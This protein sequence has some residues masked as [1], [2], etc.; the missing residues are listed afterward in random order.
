MWDEEKPPLRKG[1]CQPNRLT[2]GSLGSVSI[3]LRWWLLLRS[4]DPSVKNRRSLTALSGPGPFCPL[5]GHFPRYR[6][7]LPLTQGSF[8]PVDGPY[9]TFDVSCEEQR[10]MPAYEEPPV[11]PGGSFSEELFSQTEAMIWSR[12]LETACLGMQ[13]TKPLRSISPR[14]ASPRPAWTQPKR[15]ISVA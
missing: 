7:N 5:R 8:L 11:L 3:V 6:G 9:Y 10:A 14:P 12:T 1:R 4:S 2:E 13:P 15:W